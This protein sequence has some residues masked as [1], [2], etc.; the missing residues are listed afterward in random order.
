M[1]VRLMLCGFVGRFLFGFGFRRGFLNGCRFFLLGARWLWRW[2]LWFDGFQLVFSHVDVH[3]A[4]AFVDRRLRQPRV[5]RVA[6][7]D[8]A[9]GLPAGTA[10]RFPLG[11]QTGGL[12]CR[13]FDSEFLLYR[14][15]AAEAGPQGGDHQEGVQGAKRSLEHDVLEKRGMQMP[16]FNHKPGA[17]L[18]RSYRLWSAG[19]DST[20]GRLSKPAEPCMAWPPLRL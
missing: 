3:V 17:G 11:V 6:V 1:V 2:Q 5:D 19:T 13:R 16:H 7:F 15:A 4:P 9:P 8:G 10:D 18:S 20:A 14:V 12:G